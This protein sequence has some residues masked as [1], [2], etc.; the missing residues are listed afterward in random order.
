MGKVLVTGYSGF[1]GRHLL[2][3]FEN[4]EDVNLLGRSEPVKC[5]KYL[6][7]SIDPSSD[8]SSV[9]SQVEVVVHIAA[10]VHVMKEQ[11]T[12]PLEEFRVVNT[13]GT[14]NLA[15]QA[16]QAGVKRFVF[17]S[18]IK[19]NGESTT[20]K[21][22]FEAHDTPQPEDP[23]GVSKAEAEE[24]LIALGKETGLE[25]VIIR[26]PL[27]YGEGVKANF[28]ALLNLVG[29][30]LPLPF[31]AINR[32]KRSLV[33]VYNLV[34]LITVCLEHPNA[35]NQTFLIS[36]DDDVSTAEMVAMMAKVQGKPNLSIPVPQWCF[37]ILGKALAKE[38][39]VDRLIGS[40][41]VDISHTKNTL[42]WRPPHSIEH[43]FRLACKQK[44]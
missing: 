19:V 5:N 31:R 13:A 17:V 9:L 11:A 40:L 8:Y 12:D 30:G 10:R 25:I 1:V 6:Q 3:T 41:Q 32:N 2:N 14:L 28:A 39:I 23:Y 38:D 42:D 36:D 34:D 16:A 27:V 15:R 20:D 21:Q 7:A 18:S 33:S 43:G 35:A 37:K 29:K 44:K 26:P 4:L 22:A 24:Q